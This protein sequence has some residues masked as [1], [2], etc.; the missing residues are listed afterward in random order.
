MIDIDF[1]FTAELWVYGGPGAWHFVTL[2]QDIAEQIKFF[3]ERHYGFGT[4]Q[5]TARINQTN[6]KTSLFPDKKSNSFLLPI[7]ADVRKI[8]SLRV[9][10]PISVS[11]FMDIQ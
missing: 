5:V 4:I 8:E 3:R 2:P 7:K 1:H 10:D 6:W 9:G 11:I